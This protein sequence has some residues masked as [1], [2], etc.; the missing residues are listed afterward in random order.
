MTTAIIPVKGRIPLL[1]H[2][3]HRLFNKNGVDAV[4]CVGDDEIDRIACE[5]MGAVW[6]QHDNYPLGAKW[7]AGFVRAAEMGTEYFL[8]VGS[9]DWL[10]DNWLIEMLPYL[11]DYDMVGKPDFYMLDIETENHRFR[12]CHWH[13]YTDSSRMNEPIGIGRLIRRSM[14][15]QLH[16]EPFDPKLDRSLDW[17]MYNNIKFSGG[18]V[19]CVQGTLTKSLSLSCDKWGNKHNFAAHYSNRIPSTKIMLV[20]ELMNEFPESYQIFNL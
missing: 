11:D 14:L 10:S 7:N 8:F 16:F 12:A 15:E 6:V 18:T 2:T 20:D 19:K 17:S 4:V 13:G 9:S 3:I 5:S 1:I